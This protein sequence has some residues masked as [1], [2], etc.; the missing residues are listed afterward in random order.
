MRFRYRPP[1]DVRCEAEAGSAILT[2]DPGSAVLH[3]LRGSYTAS[4]PVGPREPGVFLRRGPATVPKPPHHVS[5]ERL[6]QLL[7]HHQPVVQTVHAPAGVKGQQPVQHHVR[8]RLREGPEAPAQRRRSQR[9]R[10]EPLLWQRAG[11]GS[12]TGP[13]S[14]V[15]DQQSR[16]RSQQKRP[17]LSAAGEAAVLQ[18]QRRHGDPPLHDTGDIVCDRNPQ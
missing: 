9:P 16:P 1:V 6:A 10:Q 8:E 12:G 13:G 2:A 4:V 7:A 11:H 15:V 3:Q 5:L 17:E 18:L 14:G